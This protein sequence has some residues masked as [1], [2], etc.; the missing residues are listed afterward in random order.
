M[1]RK[2][3]IVSKLI[4]LLLTAVMMLSVSI[5]VFAFSSTDKGSF[6]VTGL[7]AS[8]EKKV[9]V[10]AYP[11][12]TVNI[13]DTAGQPKY[14]M[15]QWNEAVVSWM[16]SN[17]PA[18]IGT[19]GEVADAFDGLTAEEMDL[20]LQKLT[21]AIKAGKDIT[22][23][24]TDQTATGGS[25]QFT[26]MNMGVYL[27][28][29]SGGVKLYKP[30]TVELLPV[31]K[32]GV[33]EVQND[34]SA[35]MKSDDPRIEKTVTDPDKT[36]AIGDIVNYQLTVDVPDYPADAT[37]VKLTVKDTLGT[38]L[39]LNADSITVYTGTVVSDSNKVTAG[40]T[41]FTTTID[42]QNRNAFRIE[43]AEEFII[44]HVGEQLTVVYNAT[45]NENAFTTDSLGNEAFIG[46]NNDPYDTDS[47]KEKSD[48][49]NVYT[50]GI[51]L[52]KKNADES[53]SLSGAQFEIKKDSTVL[54]FK[55]GA[56]GVYT[57]DTTGVSTVEVASAGTLLVKGL[58]AGTY[59]LKETKAPSG[60][61][62]PSGE[63]TVVITDTQPDG[64]I[65]NV[66]V[67]TSGN[68]TVKGA[69]IDDANK[70]VIKFNVL[71]N[72]TDFTLPV[73]GGMGTMIFTVI[74]IVLM[75]GAVTMLIVISRKKR[76]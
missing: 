5:T 49:E 50:Y 75:A 45:V 47:Y 1:K 4:A 44:E 51:S 72:D 58:D 27:L 41:T 60:Y 20:F 54:R 76:L 13:D 37:A 65:D 18:Y 10:S 2:K 15:Y 67:S 59:T 48:P 14:P 6:I 57:Y 71:N 38:G 17:Y 30:T 42:P 34:A 55:K 11:I 8:S 19:T 35:G 23:S 9:T 62:L 16:R 63:I 46:Y 29:A 70:N 31:E 74:G 39:T 32:N 73:T 53:E 24:S 7:D 26:N 22:L 64:E 52:V 43:F 61:A 69:A 3:A 12:I 36:V 66:K 33:W 40:G 56:D 21:A 28:T 25:V 68:A